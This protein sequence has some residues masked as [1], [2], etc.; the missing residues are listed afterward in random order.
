MGLAISRS[1]LERH[2]G[3]I[4]VQSEVGRGTVFT[5]TLPWD[6]EKDSPKSFDRD[7]ETDLQKRTDKDISVLA[8]G[9]SAKGR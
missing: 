9:A 7:S 6:A 5:V 2:S 4:E 8:V 3:N 1:I